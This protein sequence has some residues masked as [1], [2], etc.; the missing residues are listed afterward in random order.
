MPEEKP[1]CLVQ[2]CGAVKFLRQIEGFTFQPDAL[3]SA[4]AITLFER[5]AYAPR[6]SQDDLWEIPF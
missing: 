1:E 3:C 6:S 2:D 4:K 5:G